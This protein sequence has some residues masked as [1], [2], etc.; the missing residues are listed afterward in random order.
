MRHLVSHAHRSNAV[1]RH[2]SLDPRVIAQTG[3]TSSSKPVVLYR[4]PQVLARIPVSRSAWY[5]GIEA[6]R[7]PR[8]YSLGPRTT[9]WRSDD[10]E[11]LVASIAPVSASNRGARVGGQTLEVSHA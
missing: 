10:I 5:A 8:G 4:L 6:G 1:E 3:E 2:Q 11:A 9:V 7:F